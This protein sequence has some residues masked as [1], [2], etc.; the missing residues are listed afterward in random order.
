M[1][2][3]LT[4]CTT[5]AKE[6]WQSLDFGDKRL[7]TRAVKIAV[8]FLRNPFVSPPKMLIVRQEFVRS[9]A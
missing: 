7:N 2:L 8:E 3:N 4:D 1:K 5:W 9:G 6:D